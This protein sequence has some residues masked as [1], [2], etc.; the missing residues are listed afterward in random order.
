M[1]E[2]RKTLLAHEELS[3][4]EQSTLVVASVLDG[5]LVGDIPITSAREAAQVMTAAYA[6]GRAEEERTDKP[7]TREELL[8]TIRAIRDQ[9]AAEKPPP[10]A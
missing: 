9:H 2:A 8:A 4:S 7:Q 3:L 1:R 10:P 6:I 5:V